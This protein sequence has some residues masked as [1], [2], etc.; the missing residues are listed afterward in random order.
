[1]GCEQVSVSKNFF[2]SSLAGEQNK[3]ECL[4]VAKLFPIFAG[5]GLANNNIS[6]K[7]LS[8]D[9]RSSLF[10]STVSQKFYKMTPGR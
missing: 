4:S 3:L 8:M 5:T 10:F 7:K 1:V 6:L 9:K 2:S